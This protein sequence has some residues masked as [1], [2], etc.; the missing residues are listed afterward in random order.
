MASLQ[1]LQQVAMEGPA[2]IADV[3]RSMGFDVVVHP[4]FDGAPV[5]ATIAEGDVLVVMGGSMGVGDLGDARWP[6]LAAEAALLARVLP[7]GRPVI[8][9]CLGSQL[10]AHALG[11]RVYPC[12]VGDPPVRHREVGWGAITFATTPAKEPVL[13]G[14][15]ESEVVLHWHG[16]TFD[17]PAGAVRLASTLACE[18][19]MFRYGARAFALQFHVEIEAVDIARWV[20]E[21]ADFVRAA[22]GPRG[23]ARILADTE[24]LMPR[25]R[26]VGD[27]LIRNVLEACVA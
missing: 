16:D 21:D 14:L 13:A 12:M 6:F 26:Q 17:L 11:A 8:G 24:R 1:V 27:R 15:D 18:N 22:N 9:V 5:P 10:M 20:E 25:H 19:Q 4:L 23:G 2:R 3:A 7:E